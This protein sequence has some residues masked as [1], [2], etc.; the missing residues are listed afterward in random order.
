MKKYIDADKL[1]K[2]IKNGSPIIFDSATINEII[3]VLDTEPRVDAE[4]VIH[5]RWISEYPNRYTGKSYS[6]E[7]SCCGRI[8][9]NNRQLSVPELKY[10]FCPHCGAKM[11][12][13][14]GK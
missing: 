14:V 11:D 8:V 1:A 10:D 4:P 7:C 3:F 12:E 13:E 2:H 6:F 9:Y 5:A